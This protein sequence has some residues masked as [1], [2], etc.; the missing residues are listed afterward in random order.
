MRSCT[1]M[2]LLA[3][4]MRR[5]SS[6]GARALTRQQLAVPCCNLACSFCLAIWAWLLQQRSAA[7]NSPSP[8]NPHPSPNVLSPESPMTEETFCHPSLRFGLRLSMAAVLASRDA[9]ILGSDHSRF[10]LSEM[11]SPNGP[12]FGLLGDGSLGDAIFPIWSTS[13]VHHGNCRWGTDLK[14]N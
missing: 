7:A 5:A 6:F 12:F 13:R 11:A 9:K 2:L 4:L 3:M 10:L 14:G 1:V 8:T